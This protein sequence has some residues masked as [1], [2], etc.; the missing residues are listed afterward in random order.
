MATWRDVSSIAAA[1]A[2]EIVDVIA[3]PPRLTA[4]LPITIDE[5]ELCVL[6]R[7]SLANGA[8][9]DWLV[10]AAEVAGEAALPLRDMLTHNAVLGA[11]ALCLD[12]EVY[13]LRHTMPLARASAGDVAA[14]M[15]LV[16][17]EA[18]RL[19]ATAAAAPSDP[20]LFAAYAD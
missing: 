8:N 11:G 20:R 13:W 10:A 6:L 3:E 4:R 16:A 1:S 2:V 15:A 18:A 12:D 17:H 19:R 14:V 9:R 7:L 5:R